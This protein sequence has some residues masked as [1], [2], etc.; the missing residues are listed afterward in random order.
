MD[1]N[2]VNDSYHTKKWLNSCLLTQYRNN[3]IASS[4][5]MRAINI[6][7]QEAM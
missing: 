5:S 2:F 7:K 4:K 6:K 1:R 3:N